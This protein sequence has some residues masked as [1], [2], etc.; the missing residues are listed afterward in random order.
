MARRFK[1][2]NF[3]RRKFRRGPQRRIF[4]R[5]VRAVI[6]R[7]AE[8]KY[9]V[10]TTSTNFDT[11]N[12]LELNWPLGLLQGVTENSRIGRK[13]SVKGLYVNAGIFFNQGATTTGSDIGHVRVSLVYPKKTVDS[14]TVLAW[15]TASQPGLVGYWDNNMVKVIYDKT[16]TLA[17][18]RTTGAFNQTWWLKKYFKMKGSIVEYES[19]GSDVDR[20]AILYVTTD[21]VSTDLSKVNFTGNLRMSYIDI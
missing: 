15:I 19:G 16:K 17:S 3:R 11:S 10:K 1:K 20:Y 8:T 13:I 21:I 2:R 7:D 9:Y 18:A 14:S 5:R 4:R 6:R 12:N